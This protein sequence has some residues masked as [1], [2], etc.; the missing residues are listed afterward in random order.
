MTEAKK[1]IEKPKLKEAI[2]YQKN[3]AI[4]EDLYINA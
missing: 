3:Q 4:I 1:I 2:K